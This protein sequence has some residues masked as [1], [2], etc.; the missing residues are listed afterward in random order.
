MKLPKKINIGYKT[1]DIVI[2]SDLLKREDILARINYRTFKI[3]LQKPLKE[4][5]NLFQVETLAHEFAHAYLMES[6][7]KKNTEEDC[8]RF[9]SMFMM[10]A[11]NMGWLE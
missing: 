2:V 11:K 6:K 5:S 4:W 7:P 3:E 9:A 8:D 10:M 1:Y